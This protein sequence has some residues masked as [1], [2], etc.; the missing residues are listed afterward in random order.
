MD[1]YPFKALTIMT[2]KDPVII[3]TSGVVQGSRFCY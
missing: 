2:K 3:Q 1:N